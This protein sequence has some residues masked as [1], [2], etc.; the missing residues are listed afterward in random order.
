MT[1][2][3]CRPMTSYSRIEHESVAF[4]QTYLN[5][6]AQLH[7]DVTDRTRTASTGPHHWDCPSTSKHGLNLKRSSSLLNL[8][9]RL[10]ITGPAVPVHADLHQFLQNNSNYG[11][12]RNDIVILMKIVFWIWQRHRTK[13]KK[14][15]K[16]T[17]L[18][19]K[20][21]QI[22]E[23][24]GPVQLTVS[25]GPFLQT[26]QLMN[27]V[28]PYYRYT[29]YKISWIKPVKILHWPDTQK[30]K[31]FCRRNILSSSAISLSNGPTRK[32]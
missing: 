22:D 23:Q 32:K 14:G 26:I 30:A 27:K 9:D 12:E 20:T 29:G 21:R 17:L 24:L 10:T 7:K 4:H 8:V 16:Q 1:H 28:D 18:E 15:K 11:K 5:G 19:F 6:P 13:T 31:W 3:A 2:I 25:P